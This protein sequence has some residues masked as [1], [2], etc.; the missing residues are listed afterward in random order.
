MDWGRLRVGLH[1]H[2][3]HAWIPSTDCS[4][5]SSSTQRRKPKKAARAARRVTQDPGTAPEELIHL[6]CPFLYDG[7][8]A[9]G[10]AVSLSKEPPLCSNRH[11]H[12]RGAWCAGPAPGHS[13]RPTTA[14]L[15][16][17]WGMEG[18]IKQMTPLW[19]DGEGEGGRWGGTCFC[20]PVRLLPLHQ[21][22]VRRQGRAA[23][24]T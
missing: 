19:S 11:S 4:F 1:G 14:A 20:L 18:W 13:K 12:P 17:E 6:G 8:D 2:A 7:A 23:L 10:A 24:S 15:G 16:R 5:F 21:Q 9:S 22:S 3:K